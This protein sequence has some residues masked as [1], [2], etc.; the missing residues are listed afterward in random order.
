MESQGYLGYEGIMLMDNHNIAF[1][2]DDDGIDFLLCQ[3]NSA[4]TLTN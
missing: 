1:S 2:R 4:D 3:F